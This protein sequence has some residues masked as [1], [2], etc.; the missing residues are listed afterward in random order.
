MIS[1]EVEFF[2]L[3]QDLSRPMACEDVHPI[4]CEDAQL[5]CD[6]IAPSA[7]GGVW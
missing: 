5:I 7:T 2:F 4:A 3:L 6:K 1:H